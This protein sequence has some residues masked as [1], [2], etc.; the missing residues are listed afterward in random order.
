MV[1]LLPAKLRF[2]EL[3]LANQ[4]I[5]LLVAEVACGTNVAT[6]LARLVSGL[7]HIGDFPLCLLHCLFESLDSL[8]PL[9]LLFALFHFVVDGC[10]VGF[11]G[12]EITVGLQVVENCRHKARPVATTSYL[13][14]VTHEKTASSVLLSLYDQHPEHL[15]FRLV[16]HELLNHRHSLLSGQQTQRMRLVVERVVHPGRHHMMSVE[17]MEDGSLFGSCYGVLFVVGHNNYAMIRII[18]HRI[19][20]TRFFFM[21]RSSIFATLSQSYEKLPTFHIKL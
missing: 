16:V 19:K 21:P 7:L 2:H 17:R 3:A 11:V 18:E 15:S 13:P 8:Q 12:F 1:F 4:F 5:L 6:T 9:G 10:D 20:E 14:G